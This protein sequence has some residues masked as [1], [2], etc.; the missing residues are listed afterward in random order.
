MRSRTE[1]VSMQP[2]AELPR[3]SFLD[4]VLGFGFFSTALAMLYPVARYLVPPPGGEPPTANVVVARLADMAPNTGRNFKIG[5]GPALL[6]RTPEGELRAFNAVCTHLDCTVQY[7]PGASRIWCACHDGVFGLG[8]NVVSGPPPRPLERLTVN[9]RGE[10]G[11]ED[12]VVS[13]V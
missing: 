1:T 4:F 7:Q 13:R 12:I 11:S 10:P 8:G 2:P 3:R 6:I 9:V 5:N